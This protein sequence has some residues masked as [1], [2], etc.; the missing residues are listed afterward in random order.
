VS[1][2]IQPNQGLGRSARSP[3]MAPS[4]FAAPDKAVAPNRMAHPSAAI[5]I[6]AWEY[7]TE[8]NKLAQRLRN[9]S[10]SH[11]AGKQI[12]TGFNTHVGNYARVL[13]K[14]YCSSLRTGFIERAK[15]QPPPGTGTISGEMANQLDASIAQRFLGGQI[16]RQEAQEHHSKI[17]DCRVKV[18]REAMANIDRRLA[19]GEITTVGAAAEKSALAKSVEHNFRRL[20][21]QLGDT[22]LAA[23]WQAVKTIRAQNP[24]PPQ[25]MR[26]PRI[27]QPPLMVQMMAD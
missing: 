2:T 17:L 1:A 12:Y 26:P 10:L 25:M 23:I 8:Y 4:G 18:F 20:S 21:T 9:G 15:Q 5:K 27:K 24:R 16:N 19:K 3:D 22:H 13:G 7:V 14:T 11:P 6:K